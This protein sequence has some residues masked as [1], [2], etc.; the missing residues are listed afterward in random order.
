M[1]A[2]ENGRSNGGAA[3]GDEVA[4]LGPDPVWGVGLFV[5]GLLVM[6]VGG[7]MTWHYVFNVGEAILL[8]GAV[9]FLL[10]VA[11]SSQKQDPIRLRTVL[12]RALGRD[13]DIDGD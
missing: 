12:Q 5:V 4:D 9:V 10:F 1:S 8:L 11:I 13:D 3:T 6:G 7:A 2:T